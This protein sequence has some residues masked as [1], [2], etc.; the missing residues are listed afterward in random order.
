VNKP[1]APTAQVTNF[2]RNIIEADLAKGT[3]ASRK[4]GGNPGPASTHAGA[5]SDPARMHFPPEPNG[6]LHFGHAKSICLNWPGVATA[7]AATCAST[8]PIR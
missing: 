7:A 1:A 8:T 2:I 3:Y 4:W 6:Y 5:P